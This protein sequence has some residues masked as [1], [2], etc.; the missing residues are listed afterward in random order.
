[1]KHTKSENGSVTATMPHEIIVSSQP[2]RPIPLS[3]SSA[4]RDREERNGG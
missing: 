2:Q 3:D 4:E 1:M